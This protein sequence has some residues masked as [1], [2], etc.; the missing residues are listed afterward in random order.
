M[1]LCR[2]SGMYPV[3]ACALYFKAAE[4]ID[5]QVELITQ[6]LAA[7]RSHGSIA[8]VSFYITQMDNLEVFYNEPIYYKQNAKKNAEERD[9]SYICGGYHVVNPIEHHYMIGGVWEETIAEKGLYNNTFVTGGQISFTGNLLTGFGNRKTKAING[10]RVAQLHDADLQTHL[11][12]M[13]SYGKCR[14]FTILFDAGDESKVSSLKITNGEKFCWDYRWK[15]GPV[16]IYVYSHGQLQD[17]KTAYDC[18]RLSHEDMDRILEQHKA[19]YEN[20]FN[21]KYD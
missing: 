1:R 20:V 9:I 16:Q 15:S 3:L 11:S 13:V 19:H 21:E 5:A 18:G 7:L 12:E 4:D 2:K 17:L 6:Q 8:S 14:E 10:F